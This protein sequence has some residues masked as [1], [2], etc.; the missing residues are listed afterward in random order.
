[1]NVRMPVP[2]HPDGRAP[3]WSRGW[4]ERCG[5]EN[6]LEEL[7]SLT[8]AYLPKGAREGT[9]PTGDRFQSPPATFREG[10]RRG[11]E[12]DTTTGSRTGGGVVRGW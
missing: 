5:R 4:A 8:D 3:G 1:M 7:G 12:R 2:F 9:E 11:V 6:E 10:G